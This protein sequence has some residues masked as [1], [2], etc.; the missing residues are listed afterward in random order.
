[1]GQS[2]AVEGATDREVFEAYMEQVLCPTLRKGQGLWC[3]GQPQCSQRREGKGALIER[4]GC[5]LLYLPPYSPE[6]N[7]IE[8][9]L[10]PR[11]RASYG[12]PKLSRTR[13][14]RRGAGSGYLSAISPADARGIL[15][16]WWLPS[17]RP[18]S[19]KHAVIEERMMG[20]DQ[21]LQRFA[22][23]LNSAMGDMLA[24]MGTGSR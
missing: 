24:L 3:D 1:M 9:R 6:Y 10:L 14:A 18:S 17:S 19:M 15:R 11:S 21:S 2:L 13:G 16:A 7:P 23:W 12:K 22:V 20:I 4:Q 8:R 5:E